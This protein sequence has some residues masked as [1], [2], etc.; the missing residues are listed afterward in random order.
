MKNKFNSYL[1]EPIEI[2]SFVGQL[3]KSLPA[4]QETWIGFLDW[5]D[6]LEKEMATNPVFLPAEL[7]GQRSLAG[8]S[9]SCHKS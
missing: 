7:P 8:Y 9:P 3:V 1:Q 2:S 4:M 6:P 5:E